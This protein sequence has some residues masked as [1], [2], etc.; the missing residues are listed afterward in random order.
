MLILMCGLPFCG[1]SVVL[2][3]ITEKTELSICIIRPEDWLPDDID[4]LSAEEEKKYRIECWR[5]AIS[6][7]EDE[8]EQ[9]DPSE[10]IVLDCANSKYGP[11]ESLLRRAKRNGHKLVV[12]YVNAR[13]TQ[14]EAR[15]G[16]HWVGAK[17]VGN[18]VENIKD[19]LP[20]F[21]S[22]CDRIIIIENTDTLDVLKQNAPTAW[23]RLC[24]T[25]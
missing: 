7:V 2:D 20:K 4:N 14:C 5:T 23:S 17:V 3:I 13:P 11:L 12:L 9:R 1:K 19:S 8:V 24:Q 10:M 18:Y 22:K 25:M 21:K 15:A 16:D 6:A